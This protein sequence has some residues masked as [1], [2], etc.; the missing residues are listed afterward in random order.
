MPY[1]RH[2]DNQIK[3]KV[4][5]CVEVN[6]GVSVSSMEFIPVGEESY[7]YKL[8]VNGP[9][10]YFVKLCRKNIVIKTVDLVNRVLLQLVK[11]DFVVPPVVV[12]GKSSFSCMDGK[13]SM[14]PYI[15]GDNIEQGNHELSKELVTRL[16]N[17][18][19][20]IHK[21]GKLIDFEI[22]EETFANLY[23][24]RWNKLQVDFQE[25]NGISSDMQKLFRDNMDLIERTVEDHTKRG[26]E[27]K[28]FGVDFVL[29]HGDITG[30]N[31]IE[32]DAGLKLVDWDGVKFAPPER[33]INF[34]SSN[35]NFVIDEYLKKMN[36]PK[37][38]SEIRKYYGQQWSL[39]SIIGNF[40]RL[41]S[42]EISGVDEKEY[43]D[44]IE[45]YLEHCK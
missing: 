6:Y 33:D 22:P 34:F 38:Y 40:E 39:E 5:E 8:M 1:M 9:Q 41:F 21:S 28:Q 16:M 11:F 4:R 35:P 17:M 45:E 31:L 20:D 24:E 3:D 30:L 10:K 23:I 37:Y 42:G 13:I 12:S 18:M 32:S 27:C 44:E 15:E 36:R 7:S 2:D 43:I 25:K 29:T 14:F 26:K 19:V